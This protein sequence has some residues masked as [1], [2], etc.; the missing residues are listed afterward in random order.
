MSPVLPLDIIAEVIDIVE[1]NQDTNLLKE[2]AVVSH[3]F[4]QMCSK[5]LFATVELHGAGIT[6]PMYH[7]APS[8]KGFVELLKSRPD[9][10]QY[11][12]T[13][14]YTV[15]HGS[16]E[17]NTSRPEQVDEVKDFDNYY[18]FATILPNL[19]RTIPHLNCLT[20][21]ANM[22]IWN[23]L[24]AS[25]KSAFLHLMHLPTINN[26]DLSYF[27]NFPLSSLTPSVNL[28]RLDLYGMSDDDSPEIVELE[29][30][31]NIREFHISR[32]SQLTKKLL[33]AKTQDGR[34][35]FNFMDLRQLSMS[36]T[37]DE[38]LENERNIRYLLQN[39]KSLEKLNLSVG[40]GQSLVGLL[41]LDARTLKALYLSVPFHKHPV[42]LPLAGLCEELEAM[43]GH[44]MLETLFFEIRVNYHETVDS[45][46]SAMQEVEK[47][48]VKPGWSALRRVSFKVSINCCLLLRL[49][50]SE[51]L[52]SLPDKYLSHLSKLESVFFNYSPHGTC[53]KYHGL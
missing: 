11:I 14:T 50:A 15:E 40:F 49:K 42:H 39:A 41:P 21:T 53:A 24:D 13:L 6:A 46:G 3:S 17:C 4:L 5:H 23:E 22:T 29:I 16:W 26:I 37:P 12:R 19:L 36:F 31:P 28:H 20:I 44:N 45:I 27:R 38:G 7:V 51:A 18:L 32:S 47:V 2:L 52:Q 34:P 25:L 10:V 1:E 43:T 33:Y 8:K 35:A 30:M 9:V 48:L